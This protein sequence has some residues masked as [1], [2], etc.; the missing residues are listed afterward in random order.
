MTVRVAMWSG[1]RNLSTAMLR[2]FGARPDCTV[3]DEPLYA[4]YLAKTGLDHPLREAVL[5]SQPQDWQT[6][7][8]ALTGPAPTPL[9]YQKHMAHHLLDCIDREWIL[10]LRN[11][12][13]IRHPHAVVASYAKRRGAVAPEDLG[14]LQQVSLLEWLEERGQPVV[15]VDSADIRRAPEA[16]LQRLCAALELP[17]DPAMLQW[18]PG[19]R[20]SDGVWAAHWYDAVWASTGFTPPPPVPAA[21]DPALQPVVDAVM[22]AWEALQARAL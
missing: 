11:S 5:A 6:V 4:H 16:T 13:L 20:D 14:F 9:W 21:V 15:V 3:S 7:A 10:G 17:W 22:P 12:L 18:A 8:A 1:P 2:S 19:P